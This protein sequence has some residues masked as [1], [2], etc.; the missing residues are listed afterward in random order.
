MSDEPPKEPEQ[1]PKPKH[2]GGRPSRFRK[3][4]TKRM[5][6][7]FSIPPSYDKEVTITDKKG[8]TTTKEQQT[9]NR[10]PTFERFAHE[11]G[12][13]VG[14]LIDWAAATEKEGGKEFLKYPEFS[15]AY[16]SCKELQKNFIIENGIG[17]LYNPTFAIFTAK[18]ITDMRDHYEQDTHHSGDIKVEFIDVEGRKKDEKKKEPE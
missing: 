8:N 9:A 4:Y 6:D 10:L 13:C 16:K 15:K 11:L 2:P 12:V 1:E 18:N 5:L 17:G 7:F 14:T 3:E